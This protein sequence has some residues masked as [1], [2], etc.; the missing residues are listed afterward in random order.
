VYKAL[1]NRQLV[2]VKVMEHGAESLGLQ[3]HQNGE[4]RF[5]VKIKK[6]KKKKTN[7]GDL[8]CVLIPCRAMLVAASWKH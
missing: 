8:V 3:E 1:W 7:Y 2:A 6:T 4:G 5:L